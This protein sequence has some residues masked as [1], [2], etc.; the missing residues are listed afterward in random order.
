M[1]QTVRDIAKLCLED[2]RLKN[3]LLEGY[4]VCIDGK[5]VSLAKALENSGIIGALL[6]EKDSD[7]YLSA[8]EVLD[9]LGLEINPDSKV[10]KIERNSKVLLM[11]K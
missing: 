11:I 6:E 3:L 4:S 7:D 9:S 5:D 8:L 1:I 2:H 10:F